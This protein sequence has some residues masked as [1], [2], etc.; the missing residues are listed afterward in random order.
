M[1]EQAQTRS[2][3][4]QVMMM[5]SR[6]VGEKNNET[7]PRENQIIIFFFFF[8]LF[9][10]LLFNDSGRTQKKKISLLRCP[11]FFPTSPLQPP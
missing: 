11:N 1:K 6:E 3:N 2:E 7:I 5:D 10:F 9:I 8:N 4:Y